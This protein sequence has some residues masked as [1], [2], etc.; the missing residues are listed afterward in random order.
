[1]P[2]NRAL[3]QLTVCFEFQIRRRRRKGHR[4]CVLQ[5]VFRS[6]VTEQNVVGNIHVFKE[7]TVNAIAFKLQLVHSTVRTWK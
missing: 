6:K 7:N 3:C 5:M 4:S 2:V 1:M